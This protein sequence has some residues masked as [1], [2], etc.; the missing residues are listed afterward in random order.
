MCWT[1]TPT[2]TGLLGL[3]LLLASPA[4]AG[5]V[6]LE[7]AS[8]ALAGTHKMV[9]LEDG[10]DIRLN[11]PKDEIEGTISFGANR[12]WSALIDGEPL[13]GIVKQKNS[14]GRTLV[15]KPDDDTLD[16]INQA[17]DDRVSACILSIPDGKPVKFKKLR[18]KGKINKRRDTLK[19]KWTIEFRS[20]EV[21]LLWNM[22]GDYKDTY[23]LKMKG[24]LFLAPPPETLGG[25]TR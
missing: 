14:G 8:A 16:V 20:R 6:D 19:L 24:P 13:A 12:Q 23:T 2:A 3:A 21:G 17:I 25:G 7:G 11:C 10:G 18:L 9:L 5:K 15:F 1:D 4:A 22:R